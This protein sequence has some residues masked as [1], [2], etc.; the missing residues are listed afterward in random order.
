MEKIILLCVLICGCLPFVEAQEIQVK[1]FSKME[2]DLTARTK[3]RFDLNDSP[4]ALIKIETTGKDFQFEGNMIGEP[5]YQKGEVQ[6]YLTQGT[7][8]LTLKHDKYGI[9]RYEFPEKIEKQVVYR[10]ALKLVEDK[11]NKVRT[12]VM[13][14]LSYESSSQLSYGLMV[15]IVKKTGGYVKVKT[16]FGSVSTDLGPITDKSEYWYTGA[17]QR[18]RFAIT[19]GVLQ[20]LWTQIYLY[21]GAGYGTHNYAKKIDGEVEGIKDPYAKIASECYEGVEVE[22]GAIARFGGVAISLGVQTNRFKTVEGTVG[23]GIMF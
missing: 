10:L 12:L 22:I 9:L 17:T 8:R 4:C 13:P 23:I 1:A 5:I 3:P 14:V 6:I 15:G 20:R 19:G 11:N 16:D 18:S 7:R 2:R 21:A